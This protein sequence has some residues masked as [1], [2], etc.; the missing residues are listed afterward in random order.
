MTVRSSGT[1][2]QTEVKTGMWKEEERRIKRSARE[3]ATECTH[4][5]YDD[6]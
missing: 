1:H 5:L 4:P 2:P 6:E 3:R